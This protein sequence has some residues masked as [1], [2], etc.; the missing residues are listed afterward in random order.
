[1]ATLKLN[2]KTLATQTSSAE[3][4]IAS[5][6]TGGA[7]LSGMTSLG[8]VTTGTY[9]ATIGSSATFP[10][11]HPK[12][13]IT[14]QSWG[15]DTTGTTETVVADYYGWVNTKASSTV[16]VE[17]TFNGEVKRESGTIAHRYAYW[18]MYYSTSNVSDGATSSFGTNFGRA[19]MGREDISTSTAGASSFGTMTT[20]GTFTSSSTIGTQYYFGLTSDSDNAGTRVETYAGGANGTLIKI[21]EY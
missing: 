8:T 5:T 6:V 20:T 15:G 2:T 10:S 7:G 3:P 11:T 19:Y 17:M 14:K 12:F 4:V 13:T 16:V 18:N 21:W 9:N 1:M